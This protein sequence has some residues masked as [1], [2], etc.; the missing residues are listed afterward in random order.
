MSNGN[1]GNVFPQAGSGNDGN[2]YPVTKTVTSPLSEKNVFDACVKLKSTGMPISTRNVY[3]L[4]HRGSFRDIQKYVNHFKEL[5]L[6][7]Q[8]QTLEQDNRF[9][10]TVKILA[11]ML[12]ENAVKQRIDA[13]EKDK[14]G[15]KNL[16]ISQEAE[17]HKQLEDA[18]ALLDEERQNKA[19][20]EQNYNELNEKY[21]ALSKAH[22]RDK[23]LLSEL[24]AKV[25][26]QQDTLSLLQP[27]KT[28]LEMVT[29]DPKLGNNIDLMLK[30]EIKMN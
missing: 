21:L 6:K 8:L 20:L 4:L 12:A 27:L 11:E 24:S 9:S 18:Y 14:S 23:V 19:V 30:K 15:L 29:H 22:D 2:G 16:L 7:E 28:L 10:D 3:Q 25:R 26:Q 13:D 1:N 17:H 5:E